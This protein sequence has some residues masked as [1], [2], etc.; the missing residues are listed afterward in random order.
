VEGR[1]QGVGYRY[2]AARVA[3]ELGVS[4]WVRNLANGRV[5]AQVAGEAAA[6]QAFVERLREGPPHGRVDRI[7]VRELEGLEGEGEGFEIRA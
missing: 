3:R 4:G 5:E 2:F 1:V 6:V 7:E